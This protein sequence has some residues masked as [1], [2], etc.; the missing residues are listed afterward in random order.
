[1][2]YS[3]SQIT[4]FSN[5]QI[6]DLLNQNALTSE[7]INYIPAEKIKYFNVKK[8]SSLTLTNLVKEFG[9]EVFSPV[10]IKYIQKK[11]DNFNLFKDISDRQNEVFSSLNKEQIKYI[12]FSKIDFYPALKIIEA[13]GF[14]VLSESQFKFLQKNQK[15]IFNEL[16]NTLKPHLSTITD[17]QI[18]TLDT[19]NL[20]LNILYNI[21]NQKDYLFFSPVQIKYLLE[22]DISLNIFT[23]LKDS[24][25]TMTSEQ[26]KLINFSKINPQIAIKILSEN[27]LDSLSNN[28]LIEMQKTVNG[29]NILKDFSLL[30]GNITSKL[31]SE[32]FSYLDFSK[33]DSK[34]IF[35]TVQTFGFN[36]LSNKQLE[37]LTLHREENVQ[38]FS[39]FNKGNASNSLFSTLD[40][41]QLGSLNYNLLREDVIYNI[42][43]Q[44]SIF[45]FDYTTLTKI[46]EKI[47]FL[48]NNKQLSEIQ[49]ILI[50]MYQIYPLHYQ[51]MKK[52][53]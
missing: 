36:K 23:D 13:N 34:T 49:K 14:D 39:I 45:E 47:P 19:F 3:L 50:K 48:L 21:I 11:S 37:D 30:H 33:L 24:S 4:S 2:S 16:I 20:D 8:F 9:F 46:F 10:Q 28:Q 35:D 38:G 26:I 43:N 15:D 31:T 25:L 51:K 5:N 17:K 12:D 53:K 44:N 32:Q 18:K 41:F 7:E 6:I 52:V 22:K 42:L 27:G 1:M 29:L 40:T